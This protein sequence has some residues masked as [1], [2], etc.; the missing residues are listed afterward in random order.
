MPG[1]KSVEDYGRKRSIKIRPLRIS[2]TLE[3]H[4]AVSAKEQVYRSP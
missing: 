1:Q 4:T 2:P 3:E